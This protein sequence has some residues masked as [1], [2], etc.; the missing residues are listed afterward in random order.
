MKK[1]A[2]TLI[3]LLVVISIIAILAS[4]A[5]PVFGKAVENGKAVDCLS[6]VKGLALG[7][8]AY[9][10]D[11]DD[12]MFAA[13][14]AWP[15]TLHEKYV[16][17]WKS[18]RSPFDK[19][20][21]RETDNAPV[22]YG[23]NKN[24]HDELASKFGSASQLILLAAAPDPGAEVKFSGTGNTSVSV[25]PGS[26]PKSG[27]HNNRTKINVAYADGHASTISAIDFS[28]S[29]GDDGKKRWYP[30]DRSE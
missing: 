6:K 19:R 2:F 5:V 14:D 7:T 22:S 30:E 12:T 24:L 9:L 1:S 10:N 29:T 20:P 28:T 3:E 21:D 16:P 27:V 18:F 15:K 26:G 8:V 11:N 17:N 13:G 23:V 4:I 25:S